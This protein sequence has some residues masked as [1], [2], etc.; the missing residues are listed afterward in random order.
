VRKKGGWGDAREK[1]GL[2]HE[3]VLTLFQNLN[4]REDQV[5]QHTKKK[6]KNKKEKKFNARGG[7]KRNSQVR[8]ERNDLTLGAHTAAG[9]S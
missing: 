4:G 9:R 5:W 1:R 2:G 6:K 7:K 8:T 3:A